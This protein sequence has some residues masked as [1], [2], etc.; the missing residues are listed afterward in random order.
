MGQLYRPSTPLSSFRID[1]SSAH[2]GPSRCS[3]PSTSDQS[4]DSSAW[5]SRSRFTL[6]VRGAPSPPSGPSPRSRSPSTVFPPGGR[7]Y[8]QV[9]GA[10]KRRYGARPPVGEVGAVLEAVVVIVGVTLLI[11][12][13]A[14]GLGEIFRPVTRRFV[15]KSV[16]KYFGQRQPVKRNQILM[17][18]TAAYIATVVTWLPLRT[19]VHGSLYVLLVVFVAAEIIT[20]GAQRPWLMRRPTVRKGDRGGSV[21]ERLLQ[22]DLPGAMSA[23]TGRPARAFRQPPKR[24]T[25]CTRRCRR[26]LRRR[27][28][29][30]RTVHPSGTGLGDALLPAPGGRPSW[31][32]PPPPPSPR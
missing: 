26:L 13:R 28:C 19:M 5:L 27:D 20:G 1:R 17:G 12:F 29:T 3:R 24:T 21:I 32:R 10:V 31:P 7:V 4:A 30:G 22:Q 14:A 8:E 11:L 6:A 23:G 25:A 2:A 9:F 18:V 15:P 16:W